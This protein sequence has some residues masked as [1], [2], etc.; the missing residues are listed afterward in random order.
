MRFLKVFLLF[1]AM[2]AH[3][4][5]PMS[6]AQMKA[7]IVGTWSLGEGEDYNSRYITYQDD[8]TVLMGVHNYEMKW[9]VKNG[10][11]IETPLPDGASTDHV[12]WPDKLVAALLQ[13]DVSTI[14]F[15]TNHEFLVRE[16]S[17]PQAYILMT[18]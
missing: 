11:L 7:L 9:D 16:K 12:I 14:L 10:E 6:D 3:A 5:P 8:G 17:A 13:V 15:L 18:R 2:T 4:H 1:L